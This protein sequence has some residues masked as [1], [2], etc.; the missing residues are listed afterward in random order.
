MEVGPPEPCSLAV[1]MPKR[2]AEWAALVQKYHLRSPTRLREFV[3]QSF[4]V[5]DFSFGFGSGDPCPAPMLVST[6]KLRQAGFHECLD[7][8]ECFRKWF[9]R[10][11]ELR[12]LPPVGQ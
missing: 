10:F 6:I 12:W 3:G 11:Q 4:I 7:T 9:T 2:E 1:E 5:T 8:E